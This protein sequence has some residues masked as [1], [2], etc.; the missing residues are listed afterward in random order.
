MP[1][2]GQTWFRGSYFGDKVPNYCPFKKSLSGIVVGLRIRKQ[3]GKAIIFRVRRGNGHYSAIQGKFY[4]DKYKYVVPSSINHA[5]GQPA[6]NAMIAGAVIWKTVLTP[7]E[8]AVYCKRAARMDSM[9]GY[10]LFQKEYIR[11]HA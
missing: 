9:H 3:I 2:F 11:G 7:A 6:R 8:K 5:N 4:Q 1:R 10:V